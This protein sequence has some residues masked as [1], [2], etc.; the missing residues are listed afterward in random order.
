MTFYGT[1]VYNSNAI[2]KIKHTHYKE[3]WNSY[4]LR[5][6][7]SLGTDVR[8]ENCNSHTTVSNMSHDVQGAL[9]R[10]S[11]CLEFACL[12]SEPRLQCTIQHW[13]VLPWTPHKSLDFNFLSL[14]IQKPFT[15]AACLCLFTSH[16]QLYNLKW[17]HNSHLKMLSYGIVA[18][19]SSGRR[20][21]QG[22]VGCLPKS[23]DELRAPASLDIIWRRGVLPILPP[24]NQTWSQDLSSVA[25][26]PL[27]T[28]VIN[29]S[30]FP[31]LENGQN[32]WL[33]L[34]LWKSNSINN[35]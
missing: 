6:Q 30:H 12:R 20:I 18:M 16:T 5:N 32:V 22:L 14:C 29:E 27:P 28:F 35:M 31:H 17:G 26:P 8:N 15:V 34:L 7:V 19:G 9:H 33:F 1:Q 2:L 25:M 11:S 3:Y 21:L 10:V 13:G 4:V 23:K 24:E